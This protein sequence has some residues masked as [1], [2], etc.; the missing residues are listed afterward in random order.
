MI[1]IDFSAPS[2]LVLLAIAS[3]VSVA[4]F[5]RRRQPGFPS[6][7][8]TLPGPPCDSRITG[9]LLQILG[10]DGLKYHEKFTEEFGRAFRVCGLFGVSL[11]RVYRHKIS[12]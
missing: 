6:S 4:V 3:L 12:D 9:N 8:L 1:T 11:V 5:R 10:D 2:A 7:L